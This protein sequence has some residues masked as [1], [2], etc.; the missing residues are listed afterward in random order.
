[1]SSS[2]FSPHPALAQNLENTDVA[3]SVG[4]LQ[5]GSPTSRAKRQTHHV[6]KP[7]VKGLGSPDGVCLGVW[8]LGGFGFSKLG[9]TANRRFRTNKGH[10]LCRPQ[11]ESG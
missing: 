3:P 7:R 9:F 8:G 6:R 1:M 2:S 10:L 4:R 5:Q 11:D